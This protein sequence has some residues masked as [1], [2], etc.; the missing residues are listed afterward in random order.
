[1]SEL[2]IDVHWRPE[3]AVVNLDHDK[4]FR[5]NRAAV[6]AAA[7]AY[8]ERNYLTLT[9]IKH[10]D[11]AESTRFWNFSLSDVETALGQVAAGV[12]SQSGASV[13]VDVGY[14][15][16]L[17]SSCGEMSIVRVSVHPLA[18]AAGRDAGLASPP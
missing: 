14:Q 13:W 2:Q 11:R 15:S 9:T 7:V 5:G 17:I 3:G 18:R 12:G 6:L 4:S 16:M 10:P 8:I 1:M